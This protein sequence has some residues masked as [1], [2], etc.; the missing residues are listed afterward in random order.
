MYRLYILLK[1]IWIHPAT[2]SQCIPP[3]WHQYKQCSLNLRPECWH[4]HL[5]QFLMSPDSRARPLHLDSIQ[6]MILVPE[7]NW[8]HILK[9]THT[10]QTKWQILFFSSPTPFHWHVFSSHLPCVQFLK[11]V[12]PV[13]RQERHRFW[14]GTVHQG[15]R[16]RPCHNGP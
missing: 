3:S 10:R 4:I 11:F 6:V 9:T 5:W 14:Y 12:L 7:R 1:W 2:L 8:R 15:R 16:L 13:A